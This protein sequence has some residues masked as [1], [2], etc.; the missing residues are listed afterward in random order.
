MYIEFPRH[1]LSAFGNDCW[2]GCNVGILGYD[3]E[4]IY[5]YLLGMY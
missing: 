3:F 2:K 4:N 5:I 1:E